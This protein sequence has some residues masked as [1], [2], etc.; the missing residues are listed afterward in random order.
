MFGVNDVETA[1]LIARSIGKTDAH[2]VTRSWSEGKT[3]SAEHISGRDLINADEIMRLPADRMILLRQG[4]RPAWV[5][6]VRYYAD[7]EFK[8]MFDQA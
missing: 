5:R 4:L 7:A 6:K 8:G 3:S 1:G 2:Y